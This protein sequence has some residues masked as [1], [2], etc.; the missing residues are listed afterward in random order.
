MWSKNLNNTWEEKLNLLDEPVLEPYLDKLKTYSKGLKA[1]GYTLTD[2]LEDVY[3]VT[4]RQHALWVVNVSSAP[5]V[6]ND[7][8]TLAV[9][10]LT[11]LTDMLT[12]STV[13]ALQTVVANHIF[14]QRIKAANANLF[15]HEGAFDWFMAFNPATASVSTEF[16]DVVLTPTYVSVDWQD[17]FCNSMAN[18]GYTIANV[19]TS[20][21]VYRKLLKNFYVADVASD[22]HI[23]LTAPDGS[24]LLNPLLNVDN[25]TLNDDATVL[26]TN[27]KN[28][29][30]NG[31]YK[32]AANTLSLLDSWD[33]SIDTSRM[34][35]YVKNG[36]VYSYKEF[37]LVCRNNGTYP[38]AA[39]T[40][41]FIQR[42]HIVLRN[43]L[44]YRTAAQ[45]TLKS[46][47][48]SEKLADSLVQ[49]FSKDVVFTD[50]TKAYVS[51]GARIVLQDTNGY[52]VLVLPEPADNVLTI[53]PVLR[54]N[55][56]LNKLYAVY[57][58]TVTHQVKFLDYDVVADSYTTHVLLGNVNGF[59]L[60]ENVVY[61]STSYEQSNQILRLNAASY[62]SEDVYNT[63]YL[64]ENITGV[65]HNG[66][67]MLFF[68]EHGTIN[69]VYNGIKQF[70]KNVANV[71]NIIISLTDGTLTLSY[72]T[73]MEPFSYT[74][75]AAQLVAM[76]S[77][78][79]REKNQI[80]ISG[81]KQIGG[82]LVDGSTLY[83]D[84]VAVTGIA[85]ANRL[86]VPKLSSTAGRY[87]D[88]V[89]DN[90][91]F[92]SSTV[93]TL[94]KQSGFTLQISV[95]PTAILPNSPIVYL[96]E[97]VQQIEG[98]LLQELPN[99]YVAIFSS[100]DSGFPYARIKSNGKELVVKATVKLPL[101]VQTDLSLTWEQTY[102]KTTLR[103]FLDG[104]LIADTTDVRTVVNPVI[105]VKTIPFDVVYLAKSE[106]TTL[107]LYSGLLEHFRV[108]NKSLNTAQIAA[109]RDVLITSN[110]LLYKNLLIN[111][112]LRDKNSLIA[113]DTLNALPGQFSGSITLDVTY[114]SISHPFMIQVV[115]NI[116]YVLDRANGRSRILKI[117]IYREVV[118]AVVD[119]SIDIKSFCLDGEK[120]YYFAQDSVWSLDNQTLQSVVLVAAGADVIDFTV[121]HG[122]VYLY[123]ANNV[124]YDSQNNT[125]Y[126]N[127]LPFDSLYSQQQGDRTL[128]YIKTVG[129]GD[130][131]LISNPNGVGFYFLGKYPFPDNKRLTVGTAV[132]EV[133]ANT[134][135]LNAAE[136]TTLPWSIHATISSLLPYDTDKLLALVVEATKVQVWLFTPATK[137]FTRM[138]VD[139]SL[140]SSTSGVVD[141][142]IY[143]NN[144]VT[145]LS[146]LNS[147]EKTIHWV[148]IDYVNKL[149]WKSMPWRFG[150]VDDQDKTSYKRITHDNGIVSLLS[151]DKNGLYFSALKNDAVSSYTQWEKF[152]LA[153]D[154]VDNTV[155][156][157]GDYGVL[158]REQN[159]V[160]TSHPLLRRYEVN[161][162]IIHD[163]TGRIWSVGDYGKI[164]Y[165]SLT[166]EEN[167][168][169]VS[170]Q[171]DLLA[172]AS[173][174][175][176]LFVVGKHN[177][178]LVS[179]SSGES[180]VSIDLPEELGIHDWYAV[181]AYAEDRL[182][183]AGTSGALALL[184]K[185]KSGWMVSRI[186]G[187]ESLLVSLAVYDKKGREQ[188]IYFKTI[189]NIISLPGA[190]N[191]FVLVGDGDLVAVVSLQAL[192]ASITATAVFYT[193][194]TENN[195]LKAQY[196]FDIVTNQQSLLLVASNGVYSLPVADYAILA[197]NT[198]RSTPAVKVLASETN[199][200]DA[201]Y[202]KQT[203]KLYSVG[204][205]VSWMSKSIFTEPT[206][207]TSL[208]AYSTAIG[209]AKDTYGFFKPRF[210]F[211]DYF[212]GRKAN[213]HAK[214]GNWIVPTG[215]VEKAVLDCFYF[216]PNDYFELSGHS[217]SN[218]PNF[219]SYLDLFYLNRRSLSASTVKG[220]MEKWQ[221][222]NK[223]ITATTTTNYNQ[224]YVSLLSVSSNP[225]IS[226]SAYL[227]TEKISAHQV[228]DSNNPI[229]NSLA[230]K[231]VLQTSQFTIA[232]NDVLDVAFVKGSNL[233]VPKVGDKLILRV[234]DQS[235][236]SIFSMEDMGVIDENDKITFKE[237][238]FYGW[239]SSGKTLEQLEAEIKVGCSAFYDI[240]MR[241]RCLQP[242]TQQNLLVELRLVVAHKTTVVKQSFQEGN[243]EYLILP[244]VWNADMVYELNST[245]NLQV[246]VR[247]LNYFNGDI[248]HLQHIFA[249]HLIGE[250]YSMSILDSTSIVVTGQVNDQNIYYNL[251][252]QINLMRGTTVHTFGVVYDEL[253]VYTPD[254]SLAKLLQSANP[255]VFSDSYAFV[256]MPNY[257]QPL[258]TA[259]KNGAGKFA[260][261]S[262]SGNRIYMGEDTQ[263]AKEFVANT[264]L[265]VSTTSVTVKQIRITKVERK[266]YTKAPG[267]F[268]YILHTDKDLQDAFMGATGN[269]RIRMRNLVSEI[270]LD[271]EATDNVNFPVVIRE[272]MT[273]EMNKS[274]FTQLMTGGAYAPYLLDDANVRRYITG[275]A[276]TDNENNWATN[277][278][279]WKRDVNLV[280]RPTDYYH[281]GS[282]YDLTKPV[283]LEQYNYS[284]SKDGFGLKNVDESRYT[285]TLVDGLSVK[286]L[287]QNY[288]WILNA[289]LRDAVVG[290]D[291]D[292]L[293]F[294]SGEWVDGIF[295]SGKWYSGT[296]RNIE[297]IHGEM[298]SYPV[299]YKYNQIT[300]DKLATPN[301]NH[302]NWYGGHWLSGTWYSGTWHQG[303]WS[304]GE[305]I[306][307]LW[308]NGIHENGVWRDG[309]FD[310]GEW[311]NGTWLSGQFSQNNSFSVWYNGMWFGGDFENGVWKNGTW[312]E[313]E[314]VSSRFGTKA[315]YLKKALWEY[316]VWKN[317]SFYSGTTTMD[318]VDGL[319]PTGNYTNSRWL[320]GVWHKGTFYGGT[321]SYGVWR[322][323]IWV[324][325]FMRS[326]LTIDAIEVRDAGSLLISFNQK[327]YF[328]DT[329]YGFLNILGL[330]IYIQG[331]LD[332]RTEFFGY[333]AHPGKHKV[334][335][336]VDEYTI[337]IACDASFA[338]QYVANISVTTAAQQLLSRC[339]LGACLDYSSI[340]VNDI[341]TVHVEPNTLPYKG[342]PRPATHWMNGTWQGGIWEFG[343]FENGFF[344]SGMWVDGAFEQGAFGR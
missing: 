255:A 11:N 175:Q 213:I 150:W 221:E 320:N 184:H 328:K 266:A 94:N 238:T 120:L 173:Y 344:Q 227:I 178:L 155:H 57:R 323:G 232:D 121:S 27:Q 249:D 171:H 85:E 117:D 5:I 116:L 287:E 243:R 298:Y 199:L 335:E 183:I 31:L 70:V 99:S 326:T 95:T 170:T 136:I 275:I 157:V 91:S 226:N 311:L 190:D 235:G 220:S 308:V 48:V 44:S 50:G 151:E 281:V 153:I 122:A 148:T 146:I 233:L 90:I 268:R 242:P 20:D 294:Y 195:W 126:A 115:G 251:D 280:Y 144:G 265:T 105:D 101:N 343:Y 39:E 303:T 315:T 134:L 22:S 201:Y 164:F 49:R 267:H 185:Q 68:S 340:P 253:D 271:L 331:E 229:E 341:R 318:G 219:L 212:I 332:S 250:N 283:L 228:I 100:D 73:G 80:I 205:K 319:L 129:G 47:L 110:D 60:I 285:F 97:H 58:N 36:D 245:A 83:K 103:F 230:T 14:H 202:N 290:E 181:Y 139:G 128:L 24:A 9:G 53:L 241:A 46:I 113:N 334:R 66:Q 142:I 234:V 302:T 28:S 336:I 216:K 88:G 141:G 313:T 222:I 207:N 187:Q 112:A 23:D 217:T 6:L 38:L 160:I 210:L 292:G 186:T 30:E 248:Q 82:W 272:D 189:R 196:I 330:P 56:V 260:E 84:G 32:Y 29:R 321:W 107:P 41:A 7:E 288:H 98:S 256:N 231:L 325:G 78:T 149:S 65:F 191:T 264:F 16:M 174:N 152:D 4:Q 63:T 306:N 218:Q 327:H 312:D 96:G 131:V 269:V 224:K 127:L 299:T 8:L 51:D 40:K 10:V 37:S 317:G 252:A 26:L 200:H 300:V 124:L 168:I 161:H 310:G 87:M 43:E 156:V 114:A 225:A 188:D 197:A 304:D 198:Q 246:R 339:Q 172:L 67:A 274:Y 192:A 147:D 108:W 214:D 111:S 13:D 123:K 211:L 295:E 159:D 138:A 54:Y 278:I 261:L 333:N 289:T 262:F 273:F 203:N 279:D 163:Q 64:I 324:N 254:Y 17:V 296:I 140:G 162:S 137:D 104:K 286:K 291:A 247:N 92:A 125:I 237:F 167:I 59:C 109:R 106:N 297:W 132:V 176:N 2:T 133:V 329:Q 270:S 55:P 322:N 81:K 206:N 307:G 154:A 277:I 169:E 33:K 338:E 1:A 25:I 204:E 102:D 305:F 309:R 35:V 143:Q 284:L 263:G 259:Y 93:I 75:N 145:Y 61:Y 15:N 314:R 282:D 301:N 342:V 69:Y 258:F 71:A 52:R 209:T 166:G 276:Y 45:H 194:G 293:V 223:K 240:A 21:A 257:I 316:G 239:G 244:E 86:L 18:D 158:L 165:T 12:Y 79:K 177:T 135:L 193:T 119:L 3:K 130:I 208:Y 182:I 180:F 89:D 76:G 62:Q 72:L 19:F 74:V 77:W 42:E 34:I 179:E 118:S 236:S 337:I 215:K